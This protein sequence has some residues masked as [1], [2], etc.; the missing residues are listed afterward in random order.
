MTEVEQKLIKDAISLTI[1]LSELIQ[2]AAAG[3]LSEQQ[4]EESWAAVRARRKELLVELKG[5]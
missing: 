3:G 2:R 4:A 1:W 5:L